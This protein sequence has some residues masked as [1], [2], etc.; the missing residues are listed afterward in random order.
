MNT[1]FKTKVPEL[2]VNVSPDPFME[3]MKATALWGELKAAHQRGLLVQSE[4]EQVAVRIC[5]LNAGHVKNLYDDGF[6]SIEMAKPYVIKV[7]ED[8]ARKVFDFFDAGMVTRDEARI[9]ALRACQ[10]GND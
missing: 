6:I 8:D 9:Y 3:S 7:L 5:E 10:I 4:M 1:W 2:P